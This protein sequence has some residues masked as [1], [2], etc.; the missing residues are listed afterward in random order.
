L[1][2]EKPA[3]GGADQAVEV[4]H[5]DRVPLEADQ[6]VVRE[7]SQHLVHAL[8]GRAHHGRQ[9]PLGERGVETKAAV[10]LRPAL[11]AGKTHEPGCKAAGDVEEVQLLDVGREPAKLACDGDHE[12]VAD[13]GMG[14]DQLPEPVPGQD[15]GL[16]RLERRRG[17]R[18][19]RAIEEGELAEEVTR[20]ER[21]QDRLVACLARQRDLHQPG[22]DDEQRVPRVAL[23]EDH[24]APSEP[25]DP[26]LPAERFQAVRVQA[27]EQRD[28]RQRIGQWPA[29][30][31][32]P[33]VDGLVGARSARVGRPTAA[34]SVSGWTENAP[35]DDHRVMRWTS[36]DRR[37]G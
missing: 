22:L 28:G 10:G 33:I 23:M 9:I 37:C 35:T 7:Q 19:G 34:S 31:H 36:G 3:A 30:D 21:R 2:V 5:D 26:H 25:S 29:I 27:A 13:H 12:A 11:L 24:F 15:H 16:G 6:A 32:L 18:P 17:R 4:E 20:P 14:G 1:T 8:T